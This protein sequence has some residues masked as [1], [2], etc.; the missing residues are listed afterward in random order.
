M[1]ELN[2]EEIDAVSGGG[3]GDAITVGGGAGALYGVLMTNTMTGAAYG[4][5][6]GMAAGF[7]FG[8]GYAFGTWMY[9]KLK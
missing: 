2:I 5:A 6:I 4:G 8:A 3:F 9:T 7:A 1:R